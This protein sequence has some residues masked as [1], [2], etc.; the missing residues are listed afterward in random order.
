MAV[1]RTGEARRAPGT[2]RA[3]T[4]TTALP[5]QDPTPPTT[6]LPRQ[7][8]AA[9]RQEPAAPRFA[10]HPA[11]VSDRWFVPDGLA[12]SVPSSPRRSEQPRRQEQQRPADPAPRRAAAGWD[13]GGQEWAP[14]WEARQQ[15]AERARPEPSQMFDTGAPIG[16]GSEQTSWLAQY[17]Q[18][19]NLPQNGEQAYVARAYVP[20]QARPEPQP[21]QPAGR[22]HR[23]EPTEE[24]S[25]GGRRRRADGQPSWQETV[26]R[27]AEESGSHASGRSVSELLANNGHNSSPRRRRRRED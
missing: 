1:P 6:A 4:P 25:G 26:G 22:R 24:P 9:A 11:E 23:A 17:N 19:N 10:E 14:S 5:R 13:D 16:G 3:R 15:P 2:G 21:E 8:P 20:P 18:A 27:R 12:D 7:E